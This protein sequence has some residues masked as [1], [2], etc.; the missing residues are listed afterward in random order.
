MATISPNNTLDNSLQSVFSVIENG[1]NIFDSLAKGIV[2]IFLL[3]LIVPPL[4]GCIALVVLYF[5]RANSKRKKQIAQQ[6]IST[7]ADYEALKKEYE[8]FS[9]LL[10]NTTFE[11]VKFSWGKKILV[12]PYLWLFS[13]LQQTKMLL[14]NKLYIIPQNVTAKQWREA[15]LE[16]EALKDWLE[17]EEEEDLFDYAKAMALGQLNIVE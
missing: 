5:V 13:S 9:S 1:M 2:G 8:M 15:A 16:N 10:G 17:E 6:V 12:A 14:G 7:E 4:W 3:V 11:E